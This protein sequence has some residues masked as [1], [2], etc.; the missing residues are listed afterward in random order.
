MDEFSRI[1]RQLTENLPAG[2]E[3]PPEPV[4]NAEAPDEAALPAMAD[5]DLSET[6]GALLPASLGGD[7]SGLLS[8]LGGGMPENPRL[9]LLFALRP[10]LR[11]ARCDCIDRLSRMLQTAYGIRGALSMLK[12]LS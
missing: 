5:G 8:T 12:T 3:S 11:P 9:G 2:E 10:H 7:L 6:L 1:L 4:E